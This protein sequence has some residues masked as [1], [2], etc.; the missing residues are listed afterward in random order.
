M[1]NAGIFLLYWFLVCEAFLLPFKTFLFLQ[2]SDCHY[3]SILNCTGCGYLK[4]AVSRSEIHTAVHAPTFFCS[5]ITA[6][7]NKHKI[8]CRKTMFRLSTRS[9]ESIVYTCKCGVIKASPKFLKKSYLL[10]YMVQ[11]VHSNAK[12]LYIRGQG[13]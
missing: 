1:F 8:L 9:G 13:F 2:Y 5:P 11:I 7:T 4:H 6:N 12:I 3:I 10:F